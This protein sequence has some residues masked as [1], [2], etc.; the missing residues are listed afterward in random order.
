MAK[1]LINKLGNSNLVS[2]IEFDFGVESNIINSIMVCKY[3]NRIVVNTLLF[4]DGIWSNSDLDRLGVM[5]K[6]MFNEK[7]SNLKRFSFNDIKSF[8]QSTLMTTETHQVTT[9]SNTGE[10]TSEYNVSAFNESELK[11]SNATNDENSDTSNGTLDQTVTQSGRT[12]PLS[13]VAQDALYHYE[14]FNFIDIVI[15]DIVSFLTIPTY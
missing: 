4:N 11:K 12:K 7:W 2:H 8:E 10:S 9:G 13:D 14:T 5:L 3:A 15:D 1:T 6:A